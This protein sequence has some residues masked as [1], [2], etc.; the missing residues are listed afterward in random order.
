VVVF[1]YG[2]LTL[3]SLVSSVL[4]YSLVLVISF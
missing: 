2:V 3:G 4:V 1:R